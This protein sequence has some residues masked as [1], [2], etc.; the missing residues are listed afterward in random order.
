MLIGCQKKD[1]N[2]TLGLFDDLEEGISG[3][4]MHLIC[5]TDDKDLSVA[6]HTALGEISH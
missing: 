2:L 4:D 3:I 6:L 1:V 5:I